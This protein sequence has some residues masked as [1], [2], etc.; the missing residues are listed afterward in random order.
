M[1]SL[2][3]H[4]QT[5]LTIFT[6][7][8]RQVAVHHLENLM[9]ALA[10]AQTN[11]PTSRTRTQPTASEKKMLP[12]QQLAK[13][14]PKP[15]AAARLEARVPANVLAMVK[16]AATLEQRTVTEFVVEHLNIAAQQ[17]LL[18]QTFFSVD[19]EKFK[20]FEAMMAAPMSENNALQQLLSSRSPWD[21]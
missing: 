3:V 17:V 11:R 18:D 1:C 14:Q 7:F 13:T 21:K 20:A 8:V 19:E 4:Q 5:T 12:P 9:S 16:R 15:R 6:Y 10:V 2:F